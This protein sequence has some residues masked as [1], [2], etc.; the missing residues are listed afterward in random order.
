[1]NFGNRGNSQENSKKDRLSKDCFISEIFVAQLYMQILDCLHC[2]DLIFKNTTAY[3][4]R[5]YVVDNVDLSPD[6]VCF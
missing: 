3:I 1:M 2:S 4:G 6:F 5:V